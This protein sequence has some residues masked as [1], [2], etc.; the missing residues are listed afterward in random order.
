MPLSP[1][2]DNSDSYPLPA[3]LVRR[4]ASEPP[5]CRRRMDAL[6]LPHA[7]KRSRLLPQPH[8]GDSRPRRYRAAW[9]GLEWI[10][11]QSWFLYVWKLDP[12]IRGMLV[13]LDEIQSQLRSF[14]PPDFQEAWTRLE[15]GSDAI[16]FHFLPLPDM[17]DEID[18]Y[19]T[20]NSRGKPL[21]TFENLK[22][23]LEHTCPGMSRCEGASP[24]RSTSGGQTCCGKNASKESRSHCRTRLT[25]WTHECFGFC[26]SRL[27]RWLGKRAQ[28]RR[29]VR[30]VTP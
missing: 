23:H 4:V 15:P 9:Q 22:A 13:V 18:L 11:D 24:R 20:M 14:E 19:V 17:G 2:T 8:P 3:P 25:T 7:A 6:H 10:A 21:T 12:T 27:T 16:W 28:A 5:P 1:S 29:S 30:A 26:A